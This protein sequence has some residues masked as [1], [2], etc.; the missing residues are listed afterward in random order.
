M[1]LKQYAFA[2]Q[3]ADQASGG[4]LQS[5]FDEAEVL[6][7][8]RLAKDVQEDFEARKLLRRSIEGGWQ[9]NSRFLGGDQYCDVAP[10]GDII[11]EEK[12]FFWQTRRVFNHIA[13][14]IDARMS[15]LT[16]LQPVLRVRAFSNEEG[17]LQA[18]KMAT[19]V[20]DFVRETI[21]LSA[22][23][24]KAT[25]WAEV[26]GSA[27]YKVT[28]EGEG[29]RQVAV[30]EKGKPIF[31]GEVCVSALSPFEIFPDRLDV[32]EMADV[33]S[34]IHARSVS[35]DY[36]FERFGVVVSPDGERKTPERLYLTS[37]GEQS[38]DGCV[39]LIERYT[40][41]C[42]EAP[43]GK[44]EIVAAGELLYEGELP[45][46]CGEKNQ[47]ALPFVKQDCMRLPGEFFGTSII[48]RLIPVQRAYNAVRNR[49]HEFLNRLS[50]GI[51]TVEDGAVDCDELAE[52]GLAP[53]KVLVY[54]QGSKPPEILE[55]GD[56]PQEFAREEEWLEKEFSFVS[57]VSDLSQNSTMT[58]VTSATG[59]QLLLSQDESRLA[60][61][62]KSIEEA[63]KDVCAKILRMYKQFA[64]SARLMTIAGED[65]QAQLYYFNAGDL[66]TADIRF[67]AE[68]ERTAAEEKQTILQL[69]QAGLFSDDNGKIS[70][71]NK[72]KILQ[73]FGYGSEENVRDISALHLAKAGEENVLMMSGNADVEEFDDHALHITEHTRYLLSAEA[74]ENAA[75]KDRVLAHLREHKRLAGLM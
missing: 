35:P 52:E 56:M 74:R 51:L 67:V 30:D 64:G 11:D 21:K 24:D 7:K 19:G 5:A 31:E 55:L 39:T 4:Y 2:S 16:N 44:L 72:Q 69:L 18:A 68:R 22:T 25:L 46:F 49:K 37:G 34:L 32:E 27:F 70:S 43:D 1:D 33:R 73:A 61:T 26:C 48:D 59:L 38:G 42:G 17:D 65:K 10:N 45:Y 41:P 75:A 50:M 28:W 60:A 47:R 23:V 54:R 14:T 53:G 36:I 15:K 9:L 71:E 13:P 58:N 62:V 8:K 57:G 12:R 40:A 66:M 6:R 63:L 20:L 29:G 3:H